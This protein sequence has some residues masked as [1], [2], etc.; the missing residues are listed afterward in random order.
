MILE[1]FVQQVGGCDASRAVPL[2][3]L[4]LAVH[5]MLPVPWLVAVALAVAVVAANALISITNQY[6]PLQVRFFTFKV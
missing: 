6:T 5:T 2:F 4:L 3:A 1:F